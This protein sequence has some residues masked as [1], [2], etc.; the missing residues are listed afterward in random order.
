MLGILQ[1]DGEV[2]AF[3]VT[4]TAGENLADNVN[5]RVIPGSRVYTDEH[6]GYRG[7]NEDYRHETISHG[8]GEYVRDKIIHTNSIE[9]FWSLVK[10]SYIGVYHYWSEKHIHRYIAEIS[11][12]RNMREL[13]AFDNSNGSG[14]TKVRMM[15]AGITGRHLTYKELIH[16]RY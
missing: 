10:R 15:M 13:P 4:G 6:K 8:A 1:R 11:E 2:A 14:I 5:A 7:L 12:R 3:P 9:G 16:A